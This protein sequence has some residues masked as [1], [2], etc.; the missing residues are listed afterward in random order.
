MVMFGWCESG[1]VGYPLG[2][3][4]LSGSDEV[5]SGKQAV[6]YRLQVQACLHRSNHP[7][8]RTDSQRKAQWRCDAVLEEAPAAA[9][10]DE[11]DGEQK[12]S[13]VHDA[14]LLIVSGRRR[15]CNG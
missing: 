9:N 8:Q 15:G 14:S 1:Q 10:W 13:Y 12:K 5:P 3:A 7:K 11:S 4:G 6:N 2:A